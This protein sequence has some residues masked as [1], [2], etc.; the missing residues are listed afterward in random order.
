MLN[1]YP[2]PVVLTYGHSTQALAE[3]IEL[4]A[5]H[6]VTRLIDVRVAPRSCYNLQF[7][8]D[9]FPAMLEATGIQYEHETGIGGA[10]AVQVRSPRIWVDQTLHFAVTPTTCRP[11]NLRRTRRPL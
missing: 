8:R 4:L 5:A 9:T 3:F 10:S 7:N 6:S 2:R 1:Q 11:K